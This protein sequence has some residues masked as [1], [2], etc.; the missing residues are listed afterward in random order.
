[1]VKENNIVR[2][3]AE[4]IA[5]KI[6]RGEDRTDWEKVSRTS[7]AEVEA[8]AAE[9]GDL[10][11]EFWQ[12]SAI[13]GLPPRK[14]P[15]NLRIDADVLDWFRQSGKGYQTRINNVLRAFVTSRREYRAKP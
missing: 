12:Q 11:P 6:A 8:Q 14:E 15:V 5:A 4:Q 9:D 1:M 3:S 7:S 10:L 2:Y 13:M